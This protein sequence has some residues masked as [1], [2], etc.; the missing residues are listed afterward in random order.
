MDMQICRRAGIWAGRWAMLGWQ[1]GNVGLIDG[2]C[3]AGGVH[4]CG[5]C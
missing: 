1:M 3:W 4:V 5:H 2:P